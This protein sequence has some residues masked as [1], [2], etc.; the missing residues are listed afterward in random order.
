M[1]QTFAEFCEALSAAQ[2]VVL[3]CHVSPDPDAI[4]S[5]A[6]LQLALQGSGKEAVFYL[7]EAYKGPLNIFLSSARFVSDLKSISSEAT[8]VVVDTATKERTFA[9]S[10]F[11]DSF[12]SRTVLVLDHHGSNEG[13]GTINFIQPT[14]AASAGLVLDVIKNLRLP[15]TSDTASLLF[16]GLTDDTGSFRYSNA[17]VEAFQTAAEL[18]QAGAVP[19]QISNLLYFSVPE[20]V[21]RL[22]SLAL[23]SLTLHAGG[24]IASIA[25]TKEIFDRCNATAED[26]D[27]LVD[28]ARSLDGVVCAI[29]IRERTDGWRISLRSK[30]VGVNVDSV[31]AQFGGGGHKAAAGCT[32]MGVDLQTALMQVV[33]ATE[34]QLASA[35]SS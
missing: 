3:C 14:A 13:W 28:I 17:T 19:E 24:K 27:G 15:L 2:S 31:A 32:I 34:A 12:G 26:S 1:R 35:F 9:D 33:R 29:F 7:P 8:V 20:R 5:T 30:D 11:V 25:V 10:D 4:G 21:M 23:E 6:A 18:V 16:A 22:R